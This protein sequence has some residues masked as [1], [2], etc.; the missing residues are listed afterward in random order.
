VHI[1]LY[2]Y[3]LSVFSLSFKM[4]LI[5]LSTLWMT[6]DS[7]LS[8]VSFGVG[9]SF[10]HLSTIL[11]VVLTLNCHVERMGHAQ[12]VIGQELFHRLNLLAPSVLRLRC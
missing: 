4:E 9:A 12:H 3:I 1:Q 7:S 8:G 2:T 11:L 10:G 5:S 6:A